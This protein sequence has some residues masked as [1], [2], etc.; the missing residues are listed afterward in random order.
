MKKDVNYFLDFNGLYFSFDFIERSSDK[1]HRLCFKR[2]I[3]SLVPVTVCQ[4]DLTESKLVF[5]YKNSNINTYYFTIVP[6][7]GANNE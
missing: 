6:V 1:R 3:H 4:L 2:N 5:V 7:G